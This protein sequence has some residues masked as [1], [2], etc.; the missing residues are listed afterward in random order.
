MNAW[1]NVSQCYEAGLIKAEA[2]GTF[3]SGKTVSLAMEIELSGDTLNYVYPIG[4]NRPAVVSKGA[5]LPARATV[6]VGEGADAK[7]TEVRGM[8]LVDWTRS[9]SARH[10]RW[11]WTAFSFVHAATNTRIGF[12]LSSG[13]YDDEFGH[14]LENCLF[15][16]GKLTMLETRAT[17]RVPVRDDL[18]TKQWTLEAEYNG[19]RIAYTFTPKSTNH[20]EFH[21]GVLDGDL[22]HVWGTSTGTVTVGDTVYAFE[23]VPGVMED[24]Y[25]LW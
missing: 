7:T 1:A 10:T 22:H 8:G 20:G 13:V 17:F 14:G 19:T 16:N 24:H 3:A 5:G 4:M 12:Q 18:A 9:M 11:Y 2:V 25:A 15:I 21:L 23:N 6:R